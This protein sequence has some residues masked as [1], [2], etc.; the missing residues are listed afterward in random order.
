MRVCGFRFLDDPS[1]RRAAVIWGIFA[2]ALCVKTAF[3]GS[4]HSLFPV[5]AG[6]ARHWWAGMS[7]YG[8]YL[9]IEGIDEFRY[10]PPFAVAM[11]PF[12]LFGTRCGAML[13]DLT[14]IALLL[15]ALRVMVRDILPGRWTPHRSEIFLA[16]ALAGSA[17]GLWSG[18]SNA[19]LVALVILGMAAMIRQRWWTAA[20][21][22]ATPVFIKLW[23]IAVVLLLVVYWPRQLILRLIVVCLAIALLP[24][25]TLPCDAM[26]QYETWLTRLAHTEQM[27]WRGYRDAWTIWNALWP[28]VN[29]GVYK[30]LQLGIATAVFG[31]SLWQRRRGISAAH[32]L[33]LIYA[34]WVSWQLLFGPASEQLTYGIIAPAASWAVLVSFDEK[35]ARWLTLPAWSMMTLLASG[36][37]E[38]AVVAVFPN[39]KAFL[40]LGVLLFVAWLLWHERGSVSADRSPLRAPAEG[41]SA[42]S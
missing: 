18:Q 28:P 2:V 40:P 3:Y 15:G 7:L 17:V 37:I 22:L 1:A 10:S 32:L 5:Y 19:I 25:L 8:D 35:R 6:A 24:F 41:W 26:W 20:W 13:W 12:A 4:E 33:T 11:T 36:D 29:N 38:N 9:P 27:R 39:G 34:I 23:A 21:L 16:L 42:E 14:S 30:I 31:W